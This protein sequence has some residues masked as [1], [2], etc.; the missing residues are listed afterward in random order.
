M[1]TASQQAKLTFLTQLITNLRVAILAVSSRTQSM[2]SI[3][4]GQSKETVTLVNLTQYKNMLE[5]AESDLD[6]LYDE[7]NGTGDPVF[8]RPSW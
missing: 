5:R 8:T 4:T 3:D 7:I 6:E 2:Y 1:A